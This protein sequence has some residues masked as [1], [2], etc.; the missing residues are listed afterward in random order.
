MRKIYFSLGL[1]LFSFFLQAQE[2]EL[3]ET[4]R[5]L[6]K[7]FD[8]GDRVIDIISG[9]KWTIIPAL[10]YSPETNLGLGARALRIFRPQGE[11]NQNLRPS[12]LPITFLYTLNNQ[13][14]FTTELEWWADENRS[15]LNARLELSN[16]PFKY[17]GIGDIASTITGEAYT[18]RFA[19]FFINYERMLFKGLYLGPK[20]E[21]RTDD[22]SQ[23]VEGG[24]LETDR[25][26]GYDGQRISGLGLVLNYDTRDNIF[27]PHR[28][29]FNRIGYMDYSSFLGS[30][31]E[32]SQ[33]TFDLRKYL[34]VRNNSLALQSWWSFTSANAP[35]QQI[36]LIGGSDRMRGY[37]EGKYR[38]RHA[39]VHQAE[40][41][42][43]VHR[44]L[45][46]VVF[47]HSG[48][49]AGSLQQFD[50]KRFKYGG[51]FGFRYKITDDGLN[52][53]LD[54]AIGDQRAFYFGLNEVI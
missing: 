9:D 2:L 16:F 4:N 17:Y 5:G 31:F 8:F 29:W 22:I 41:R 48:Q 34:K 53:R 44:N 30:R 35:F 46:M 1:F 52:I 20:Y 15:L 10:V 3:K 24:L 19:S 40:Y 11:K 6:D 13:S 49:V 45:G 33:L 25:P 18:T 51:G 26:L 37:F 32:F 21:F 47:A 28:G 7:L 12:T 50:W 14:I 42:F 39:M 43:R 23:R 27:Q 38:D 36:S 54:F